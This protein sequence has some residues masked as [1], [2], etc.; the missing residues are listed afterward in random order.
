MYN[1]L[2]VGGRLRAAYD[3]PMGRWYIRPIADLD[4]LNISTP[5]YHENGA[6]AYALNVR[7][8]DSTNAVI[9]PV[10]EIGG[11][12]DPAGGFVLRYYGDFGVSF[13][14]DNSRSV[15]AS[16][17]NASP[18]DGSFS[19]TIESPDVPGRYGYRPAAL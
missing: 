5:S 9:S 12:I 6:S 1:A 10:V 8:S 13:L 14:P 11:R 2:M 3:I 4:V 16:F 17:V 7:S 18:A 19:T 15:A